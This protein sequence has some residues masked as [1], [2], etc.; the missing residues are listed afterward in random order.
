[1]VETFSPTCADTATLPERPL[2]APASQDDV[3]AIASVATIRAP[4]LLPGLAVEAAHPVA[5]T[6]PSDKHPAVVHEV[7][8]LQRAQC[9]QPV[10]NAAFLLQTSSPLKCTFPRT[11]ALK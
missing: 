9:A 6:S 5:A 2:R 8:F 7:P 4:K 1:M 10:S 11:W 3:A